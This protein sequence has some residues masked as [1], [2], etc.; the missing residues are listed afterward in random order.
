[1]IVLANQTRSIHAKGRCL[2]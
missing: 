1:M 2:T